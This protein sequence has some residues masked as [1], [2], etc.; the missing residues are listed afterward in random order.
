[1]NKPESRA[2]IMAGNGM[3]TW[4]KR[5][6]YQLVLTTCPDTEAAERVARALVRRLLPEVLPGNSMEDLVLSQ[7]DYDLLDRPALARPS[8]R[9]AACRLRSRV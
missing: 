9:R 6:A 2:V 1:M 5:H 3:P 7:L 8:V 4:M